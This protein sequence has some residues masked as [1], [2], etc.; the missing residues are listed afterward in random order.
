M[1]SSLRAYLLS[2][3]VASMVMTGCA[4]GSKVSETDMRDR[5]ETELGGVEKVTVMSTDGQEVALD[6]PVFLKELPTQGQDLQ[7]SAEPLK[8][9]DVRFTLVLYRKQSAPLVVTVGEKASQF[10]ESTYRGNGAIYFYQ[11]IHKQTGKGLLAQKFENGLLSAED[12]SKTIVLSGTELEYIR[13]VLS[14]A[15]PETDKI[16]KQFPLFPTYKIRV[17][18]TQKPLEVTVLTP[19]VISVPFGREKHYFHVEGQLFSRM[20]ALLPPSE[21]E[22]HSIDR[23][24]KSSRIHL[25]ATGE[26]TGEDRE[27]DATQTTV[28]QG[29][30]HQIVRL[31]QK[32]TRLENAPQAPGKEQYQLKFLLNGTERSV[33]FYPRYFKLDQSWYA[34]D[35]L[36]QNVWKLFENLRK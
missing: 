17:G 19:T 14:T 2:L 35:E 11:W 10:G 15:V 6:L 4:Q 7:L 5:M 22:E 33:V 31:L 30:A 34:H 25:V 26:M 1:K 12:L 20:T 28:E 23:L 13:N 8:Q 18:S 3:L 16:T 27:L 24:F 29:I 9:E 36:A 21:T 32:G